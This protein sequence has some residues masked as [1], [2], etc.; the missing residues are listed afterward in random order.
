MQ[1]LSTPASIQSNYKV[2][3]TPSNAHKKSTQSKSPIVFKKRNDN[4]QMMSPTRNHVAFKNTD[5]QVL[6]QQ[7]M[8]KSAS[9]IIK[10]P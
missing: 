8:K 5:S 3:K 1:E 9:Q 6:S 4:K 10:K 7:S 2:M